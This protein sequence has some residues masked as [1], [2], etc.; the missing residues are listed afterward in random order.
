MSRRV[1]SRLGFRGAGRSGMA[2]RGSRRLGLDDDWSVV[3]RGNA[4]AEVSCIAECSAV[5][6]VDAFGVGVCVDD[7]AESGLLSEFLACVAGDFE[8]LFLDAVAG[9]FAGF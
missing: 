6:W 1:C 9:C 8:G 3:W 7:V 4:G 2:R 5:E